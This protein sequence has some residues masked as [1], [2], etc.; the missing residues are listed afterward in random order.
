MA[1]RIPLTDKVVAI[2]G[3]ARGIG[4]ATA[5]ALVA[6][7]ARVAI[8][9]IDT[10]LA[11]REAETLGGN[12]ISAYVDVTDRESFAA[13]LDEVERR[14]GPLDALVNNAGIMPI[15]PFTEESDET[16][17]RMIDI[18]LH[19]VIYGMKLALQSMQPRNA[20]HIVNLASQ[21]GKAGL[22]GGA[23]Y[24][25][26]KHGVVGLSEAVRGEL[27]DTGIEVSCVMPAIVNTE[28]TS[29]M[30]EARGV[31]SVEP[32]DVAEAIVETLQ[33]P[34]FDVHVPR[35]AGYIGKVMMAMPRAV[36]EA[37]ARALKADRLLLDVD[38]AQ[39]AAYEDRA[40]REPSSRESKRAG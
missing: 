3:G 40:A 21:A 11:Q 27:R 15:G 17:H 38:A 28:L 5:R 6:R 7:G 18:N 33:R 12:A 19:G 20:G 4:L 16:A 9:D 23:T 29:G 8:G 13:F 25:A 10:E 31:K 14:L 39:R 34:R 37:A 26:T 1:K 30:Q 35:S 2:S 24:C 32:E 22:P 36:R